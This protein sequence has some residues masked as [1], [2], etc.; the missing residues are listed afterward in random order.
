[1]T[2]EEAK[3][4]YDKIDIPEWPGDTSWFDRLRPWEEFLARG[5]EVI[6]RTDP[7]IALNQCPAL[8][9]LLTAFFPDAPR[10]RFRP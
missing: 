3:A 10:Y 7:R 5:T 4:I 1:M 8:W 9:D 6:E 2:S